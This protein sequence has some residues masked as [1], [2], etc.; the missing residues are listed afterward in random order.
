MARY[1]LHQG[2]FLTPRRQV[3]RIFYRE[4]T[5]DWNTAYSALNEDEYGLADRYPT[6]RALDIGGHIGTVTLALVL[7]NPDVHVTV[8][9]PVPDN[10][11][12]IRRNLEANGVSDR[13]DIVAALAGRH[14]T[15]TIRYAFK[16]GENEL[17]HAYIG[18]SSTNA[19][20]AEHTALTVPSVSLGDLTRGQRIDFM[21][22]DCEGGE[23]EFLHGP[24]LRL[25]TTIVGEWHPTPSEDGARTQQDI[26]DLLGPTHRV[27]FSGPE[28]GPGGFLAERR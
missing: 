3:A 7:D 8:V 28:A 4:D 23:Y 10:V 22:I 18:N 13:A 11:E 17:H 21:K 25:V 27:T 24:G 2:S 15:G 16:G 5:N 9:E 26:V 20:E 14:G 6:G 12:L 19:P 1:D